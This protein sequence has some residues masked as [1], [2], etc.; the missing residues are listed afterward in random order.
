[1]RRNS[2]A[3]RLRACLLSNCPRALHQR[4]RLDEPAATALG[5]FD[6]IADN[7][8]PQFD[9]HDGPL[10][11]AYDEDGEGLA[12]ALKLV[13][14]LAQ[15]EPEWALLDTVLHEVG[16]AVYAAGEAADRVAWDAA[17]HDLLARRAAD[18]D[19]AYLL[20]YGAEEA[21]AE[22]F[23]HEVKGLWG[24]PQSDLASVFRQVIGGGRRSTQTPPAA[25]PGTAGRAERFWGPRSRPTGIPPRRPGPQRSDQSLWAHTIGRK[26][27]RA[28]SQRVPVDVAGDSGAIETPPR[29]RPEPGANRVFI[30][31]PFT[32]LTSTTKALTCL[33]ASPS[34]SSTTS[35][36]GIGCGLR[37]SVRYTRIGVPWP[38]ITNPATRIVVGA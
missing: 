29:R 24:A 31:L 7:L 33:N 23:A 37:S 21:F 34:R 20:K 22:M 26:R 10:P 25:S 38:R 9:G 2:F 16:H 32:A 17:Y 30:W 4:A 13:L 27:H 14:I 18:E 8:V 6:R 11:T 12:V 5:V 35:L 28:G 15:D 3:C 1:M 36:A 19:A